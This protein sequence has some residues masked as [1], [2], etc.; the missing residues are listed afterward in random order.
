MK[1]QKKQTKVAQKEQ[2]NPNSPHEQAKVV[3]KKHFFEE[4]EEIIDSSSKRTIKV[5]Q[6]WI[7]SKI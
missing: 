7:S 6:N 3:P 5:V 2:K 1:A 4:V